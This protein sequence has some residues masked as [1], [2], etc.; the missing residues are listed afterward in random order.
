MYDI[1]SHCSSFVP[2]LNGTAALD[3]RAF[4][5]LDRNKNFVA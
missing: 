3:R 1:L 5:Y 4:S 2:A